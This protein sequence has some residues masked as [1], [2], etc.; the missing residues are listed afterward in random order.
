MSTEKRLGP[1]LLLVLFLA[2]GAAGFAALQLA[3]VANSC[4]DNLPAVGTEGSGLIREVDGTV[5]RCHYKDVAD[6]DFDFVINVMP[7][8]VSFVL[9]AMVALIASV[10]VIRRLRARENSGRPTGQRPRP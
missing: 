5:V 9:A 2:T 6:R 7:T 4:G 3:L 10:E 8:A 1:A